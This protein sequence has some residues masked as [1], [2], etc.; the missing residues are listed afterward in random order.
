MFQTPYGLFCHCSAPAKAEELGDMKLA[1][2]PQSQQNRS[3][4]QQRIELAK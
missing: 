1:P 2:P 4:R 3:S